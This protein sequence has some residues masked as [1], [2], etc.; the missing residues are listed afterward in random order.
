MPPVTIMPQ[1]FPTTKVLISC[2]LTTLP[3]EFPSNEAHEGIEE[4]TRY[5]GHKDY[6]DGKGKPEWPIVN[7]YF[8]ID[9]QSVEVQDHERTLS[10]LN[11]MKRIIKL[12]NKLDVQLIRWFKD[13]HGLSGHL[14]SVTVIRK[15]IISGVSTIY[16]P[17]S[18]W[19]SA[20]LTVN[21]AKR[22]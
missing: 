4:E 8:S 14:E 15:F 17:N 5:K 12:F 11:T 9:Y 18:L 1:R 10:N 22:I 6:M 16:H 2:I 13:W 3:W 7:I 20:F 19:S 21:N